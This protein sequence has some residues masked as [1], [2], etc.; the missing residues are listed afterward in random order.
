MAGPY[1]EDLF[2]SISPTTGLNLRKGLNAQAL[3]PATN[4]G[5]TL[6]GVAFGTQTTG[7]GLGIYWGTGAPTITAPQ[8]SLYLNVAGSSTTTRMYINTTGSSTWTSVTTAA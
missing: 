5:F 6:P 3:V 4:G 1:F 2:N 7:N 8:G